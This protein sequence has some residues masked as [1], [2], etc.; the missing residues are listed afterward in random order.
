MN[1]HALSDTQGFGRRRLFQE[2]EDVTRLS[3]SSARALDPAFG[4]EGAPGIGQ[5][6]WS[7]ERDGAVPFSAIHGSEKNGK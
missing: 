2:L 7:G 4:R 5:L 3:N 1:D 6:S